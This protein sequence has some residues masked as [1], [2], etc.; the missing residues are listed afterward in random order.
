LSIVYPGVPEKVAVR[1]AVRLALERRQREARYSL[2]AV[3]EALTISMPP[4]YP[5]WIDS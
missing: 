2:T 5:V 1:V 3:S 4:P